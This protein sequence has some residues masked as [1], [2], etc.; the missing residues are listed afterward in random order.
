[1][2][3]IEGAFCQRQADSFTSGDPQGSEYL[4]AYFTVAIHR[5]RSRTTWFGNSFT[6]FRDARSSPVMPITAPVLELDASSWSAHCGEVV[7]AQRREAS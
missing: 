1:M 2:W 6:R 4:F 5:S 3:T 7:G